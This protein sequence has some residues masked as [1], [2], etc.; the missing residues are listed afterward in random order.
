MRGVRRLLALFAVLL[1]FGTGCG[2]LTESQAGAASK[3]NIVYVLTDDLDTSLLRF[4]PE[5][6]RMQSEGVNFGN[7]SVTDSLCCPS[8]AA[9]LSGKF[10]HNN[11]VFTNE[12]PDGGFNGFR[13][14][15]NQ[16]STF[17]TDLRSAGYRTAMMGKYLNGYQPTKHGVPPG[18]DEWDVAGKG[19]P[20]Y[21]YTMNE[22]GKKVHYGHQPK[23]YLTDVLAAKG[24]R[25]IR[26]QSAAGNPFMMEI[27]TFAPHGPYTPA[28]RHANDFPGLTAPRDASFNEG[29]I[30]DK[31]AWLRE[32]PELNDK[33]QAKIDQDYRKRAQSVQAVD[34]MLGR[35]RAT[36]E[37]TG[38]ADNTYVMFSSDNGF[39][40]G[41]HRLASGKQTAFD[42]DVRVP[43]VAVGPGV[44][45]GREERALAQN[46]DMRSTFDE[47]VGARPPRE[48]ETDGTS[49]T[50]ALRGEQSKNRPETALVEHHGPNRAPDDPDRQSKASGNPPS[51]TALRTANTT[52]VEYVTGEREYYDRG[53][54]PDELVNRYGELSEQR[55]A[56]LH[57]NLARL[58]S[59]QGR[60]C[61]PAAQPPA[62]S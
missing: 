8:R 42:T 34:E 10:P 4:M 2:Q 25:F 15:G 53:R 20:E 57:E 35:L 7:Y 22:N 45:A 41:Q 55:R 40:L 17:A 62:G 46:I 14:H 61:L 12:A 11:G 32:H 37:Q 3:P 21:D 36:L 23:D 60:D 48:D 56:E 39:H 30:S 13:Q 5:V 38:Q 19:Y 9:I 16:R 50:P 27:A 18:W 43:L 26:D 6:R 54:D 59:C 29:D 1:L 33:Q 44:P 24:E 28:P 51:Y 58:R 49:L 47:L 31:P 52:Y